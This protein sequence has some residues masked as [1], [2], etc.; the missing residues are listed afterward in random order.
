MANRAATAGLTAKIRMREVPLD[1]LKRLARA[2]DGNPF[3]ELR[4]EDQHGQ[5]KDLLRPGPD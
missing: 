1:R 4:P 2:L 3:G 5:M